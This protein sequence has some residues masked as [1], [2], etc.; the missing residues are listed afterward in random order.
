M[1]TYIEGGQVSLFDP[2]L[3]CGKTYQ[4]PF[5]ATKA[6]TSG[7]CSKKPRVSKTRTP[8][9]LDLRK[10][11]GLRVEQYWE[12]DGASLGAYSTH[13]F[14]ECPSAAVESRLSQI[15]EDTPHPK[16]YLS[17]KACQGILT[18]ARRRG[19]PLPPELEEA[20]IRQSQEA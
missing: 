12:T 6:R 16:Y 19:K 5:P 1:Q 4:E 11:D 9:F 14:G 13:S 17:A 7:R 15:L 3:W 2:A 18:R 10:V 8:L 20:L